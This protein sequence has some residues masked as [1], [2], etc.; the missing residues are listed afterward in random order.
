MWENRIKTVVLLATLSGLL[1]MLG[2]LLGGLAGITMAFLLALLLNG[3]TY[4]FSDKIVLKIYGA[5]PMPEEGYEWL[6]DAVRQLAKAMQMPMPRLW[7]IQTPMANAFATG[8]NPEHAAIAVTTGIMGLLTIE[9]IRAVLAHEMAH[10]KNRDTLI[11]CTAATIAT[12]IGYIAN[13]MHH[14]AWWQTFSGN[15]NNNKS[16]PLGLFIIALL[17]PLAATLIRLA[18][19]RSREYLADDTG[20][21]CCQDPL[22]LASALEKLHGHIP[23][24]HLDSKNAT[25]ASAS[26]LFIVNPFLSDGFIALFSTHPPVAQ[27]IA[28]LKKIHQTLS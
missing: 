15:R 28:R 1:M 13:M 27:R 7:I 16:N 3:I 6:Y 22:A 10:I 11:S 24:A 26:H 5:R 2:S 21:H 8:R 18:I 9:E 12:A 19:S 23:E 20:A 17:M 4:F 25:Q 14:M